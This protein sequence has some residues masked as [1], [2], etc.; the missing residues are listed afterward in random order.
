MF[1]VL[2]VVILNIGHHAGING[3][4]D[5]AGGCGFCIIN[6]VCVGVAN[7]FQ[8][9]PDAKVAIVDFDVHHGKETIGMTLNNA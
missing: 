8:K 3:F 2:R 1:D 6:N 7:V 4:D 9:Y 5:Q